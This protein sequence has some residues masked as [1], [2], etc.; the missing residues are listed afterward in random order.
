MA[1]VVSHTTDMGIL[2]EEVADAA[3]ARA[4]VRQFQQQGRADIRVTDPATGRTIP[5][6]DLEQAPDD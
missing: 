6:E 2:T 1:F 5:I 3:S 4:K